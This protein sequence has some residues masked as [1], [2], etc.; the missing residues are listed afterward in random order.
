MAH[1][2][3]HHGSGGHVL[4]DP[5]TLAQLEVAISRHLGSTWQCTSMVDLAHLAS[6]PSA[7]LVGRVEPSGA[8]VR[9]FAKHSCAIEAAEQFRTEVLGLRV[10]HDR[11]GIRTPAPV[12]DGVVE[13][14]GGAVLLL[15]AVDAV[16]RG[17][18]QWRD[19]GRT[20]ARLHSVR[21]TAYGFDADGWFG[22]LPLDNRPL[23][24]ASWTEFY[25][26]RRVR[27]RLAEATAAGHLRADVARRV[28]RLLDDLPASV[29]LPDESPALLHGD[30][31]Q[32]NFISTAAGAV[33]IDPAVQ[34]GHPELDLAMVDYFAPVPHALFAGY[35]ELRP[36]DGGF[37][38]RRE[39][40]RLHVHLA[41]IAVAGPEYVPR[42]VATLDSITR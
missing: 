8:R 17:E 36:I 3:S 9:V 30:A 1:D 25:V 39:I 12:G 7:V 13:V 38:A 32:N 28:E 5:R 16:A 18:E 33:A 24:G 37:E 42:L 11:G 27:P 19:I 10:L 31:Q 6:H 35:R 21:G 20:L 22:P 40:W 15:D 41:V 14:P 26:E 2:G 29:V 4:A 23:P 34:F